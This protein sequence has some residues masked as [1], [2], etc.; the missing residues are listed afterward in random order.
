LAER[1]DTTPA[2]LAIS[3]TLAHPLT[4]SVL[5]GASSVAQL[6]ANLAATELLDRLT[7]ADLAELRGLAA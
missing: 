2:A 6:E 4:A 1:L 3:F 5:F 7:P